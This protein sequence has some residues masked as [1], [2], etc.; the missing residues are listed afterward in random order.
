MNFE[1]GADMIEHE[2]QT[3]IVNDDVAVE[4]SAHS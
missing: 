4:D 2:N 1:M 3:I